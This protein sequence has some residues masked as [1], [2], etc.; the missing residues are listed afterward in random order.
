MQSP[1]YDSIEITDE[2]RRYA[3]SRYSEVRQAIF[4]NP[5]QEI[6]G[7]K[8]APPMPL[9][10]VGLAGIL[11]GLLPF[12]KS[13][14]LLQASERTIDSE[15]DLRWGSDGKGFRRLLHPNG[16]CLTGLW[17]ITENSPYSGYFKKG[18]KALIIG[19]YSTCCTE[20]Q[21][22]R[23]RSLALAGKLYPTTDVNHAEPLPTANFF[24]QQ[25]LGGDFSDFINDAELRNAPDTRS[26]RRGMGLP[27][28]LLEGLAFLRADKQPTQRQLYEIAELGKEPDEATR[29]PEFMRLRVASGQPRIGGESL[30]FR[31]EIMAQIYDK[32]DPAPKRSLEFTIEVSDTGKTIGTPLFERR[33][34]DCWSALGQIT[35]GE[36]VASYNADFVLHFNHP[37]WRQD[38]NDPATD[39]RVARRKV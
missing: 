15:A 17:E 24:T 37:T 30:D 18:S 38:R 12:G 33:L 21:R 20:S 5:Y 29:T 22:G 11:A 39:T 26:W 31:D 16:I 35:F 34:I 25:D 32:G 19:R 3:G 36:A 13:W 23:T 28:L 2:D 9:Y 10:K 1:R 7:A 8:D 14:R 4:A 6:W 27:V